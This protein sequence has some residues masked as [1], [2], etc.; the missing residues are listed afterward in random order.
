ML[1]GSISY[2]AGQEVEGWGV[3]S[4]KGGGYEKMR[5]TYWE[6]EN[7][8]KFSFNLEYLYIEIRSL[9]I[10]MIS[11]SRQVENTSATHDH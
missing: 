10:R 2:L 5:N 9:G 1:G 7:E 11:S 3:S 8:S 6:A 4:L